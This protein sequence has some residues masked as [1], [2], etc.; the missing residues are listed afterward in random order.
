MMR[1]IVGWSLRFRFLLIFLAAGLMFFGYRDVRNMPVDVFPEF[2]PPRVEVQTLSVG[3]NSTEVESQVTI[4]LEDA[5]NGVQNL[6]I[7][8]SKSVS[9]L[10]SITLYFK[11]GTDLMRA[12][13][14]VTER[15]AVAY[16]TLPTW[17]APPFIMPPVSATRRV[18]MIGLSSDTIPLTV[19]SMTAYWKIRARLLRVP[20]VANVAIWG[21]RLKMLQVQADPQRMRDN[22]VS[23]DEVMETT[24]DAVDAGLLRYSE[25]NVIGTGGYLD[26]ANQRLVIRHVPPVVTPGDLGQV[27]LKEHPALH[28]SDVSDVVEDHQP[29]VGDAIVNDRPGLLLVVDKFPWANTLE[30]T[31][32]LEK[33]LDELRPALTGVQI[34]ANIFRPATFI[35]MSIDNL[36]RALIIGSLLVVV[37]L[38]AF[39]FEWRTALISL[40]AMP[41]SLMVALLVLHQLGATI[42]VMVL[43]G[44]VIAIGVVVDDAIIDIE[45][46]WR[47]LRQ[48]RLL[49]EEKSTAATILEASL[50]VRSAIVHATLM[51]LVVLMPVF[52]LEGLTGSFFRPL[53]LSFVL[54]VLASMFVALTVTPALGLILLS[55][56][57]LQGREPPLRRWLQ[58]GYS[59]V[60]RRIIRRPS[61]AYVSV[62]TVVLVGLIVAPQLGEELLP[63][64]KE[65]DFLTHWITAPGTSHPEESRITVQG[66]EELRAIPGVQTVGAHIG[67]AFLAEEVVGVNFG[68]NWVSVDPNADYD[69]TVAAIEETVGSYPGLLHEVETYLKETTEEVL[70]GTSQPIVVRINGPDLPV[71]R[72]KADEV[73]EALSHIEGIDELHKDLQVDVPQV[74]VKVDLE[75][76]Q[77][78]GVKPGDVRR[79]AGVLVSSEEV[80][81]IYQG[82]KTYEVQVWSTPKTRENLGS[83]EELLID[84]P[85]GGHVR[86]GD[87]AE[88]R[89]V[90]TPN[91]VQRENQSRRIDVL[92]GV[93]GRDLGSVS[94]EVQSALDEIEFPLGYHAEMLGEFSER[95]HAQDRLLLFG[96]GSAIGVLLLLGAAFG[97]W[98]LAILSFLTLPSALV[99]GV[100]AAYAGDGVISLGSLVGFLTVFG[101]A[102]RNGIMLISHFQYLEDHEGES[103]GPDLVL[104]G[105]RERIAPILMT[106]SAAA[107]ALIPLVVAGSVPGNEIEHPMA[108]VILGGLVTSTM[109]NLFIVPSLY[110]Q[111]GR[112]GRPLAQTA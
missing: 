49:G 75:K 96:V 2:A 44:L 80:A 62:A 94:R 23:L 93:Q 60:L 43:A 32:G 45:N 31:D 107:L 109:L 12:R 22:G 67:Q 42:N 91:V 24:A 103:F 36:T 10:S 99:G 70:T 76:A 74:E 29:L 55:K 47:R 110:L 18:L 35:D 71:L 19:L 102:A 64:F 83:I 66:T 106:A 51:D 86:L 48:Q 41:L 98:K 27:P 38:I 97:N 81:D 68:E 90:P 77:H 61:A 85:T 9:D 3:L 53:A 69:P 28:L 16:P 40:V 63:T 50:E 4:P 20:G 1:S 87:I 33:A 46:I 30:T 78:Y 21:E 104:R 54:A 13:Q 82:G 11:P 95:Q 84:T 112:R 34:D 37:I 15:L 8:R 59:S 56:A 100:L 6:D 72:D 57:P 105:A 7:M 14:L 39:L 88:I 108:V 17:A 58:A 5:L 52:F 65:R 26:T 89:V 111:F 92:A 73:Q 101:I 25:G 79:A